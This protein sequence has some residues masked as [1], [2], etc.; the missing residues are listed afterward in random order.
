MISAERLPAGV[1]TEKF[2]FRTFVESLGAEDL[3]R[4]DEQLSLAAVAAILEGNPRAVLFN[5]VG[6]DGG[7][8][9]GNVLGSRA[10]VAKAFGVPQEKLLAEIMRRLKNSSSSRA[11]K[12]RCT[13]SF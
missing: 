12:R 4:H 10:R 6:A 11:R 7:S 2:R 1:D 13:K 9:A 3:E 5:N 8:L